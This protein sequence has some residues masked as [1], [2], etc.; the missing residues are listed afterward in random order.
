VS[1]WGAG[2]ILLTR[3]YV[4]SGDQISTRL[5]LIAMGPSRLDVTRRHT[6]ALT[7]PPLAGFTMVSM[8]TRRTSVPADINPRR[9]K[10]QSEPGRLSGT[11][12]SPAGAGPVKRHWEEYAMSL[13]LR[14]D[15]RHFGSL[16]FS[17]KSPK[18][19]FFLNTFRGK[20]GF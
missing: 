3:L 16:F 17:Q 10:V 6:D 9:Q 2:G 13:S 20:F 1:S 7:H 4:P 15:P 12:K 11:E 18:I 5:S 14:G 8:R 19:R